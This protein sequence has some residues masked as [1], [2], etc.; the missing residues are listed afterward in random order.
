MRCGPENISDPVLQDGWW[1]FSF[2]VPQRSALDDGT[3]PLG[4]LLSDCDGVPMITGLSEMSPSVLPRINTSSEFKN[5]H[6]EV[7]ND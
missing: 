5:I 7:L 1:S 3:G 4:H 2:D 6:F